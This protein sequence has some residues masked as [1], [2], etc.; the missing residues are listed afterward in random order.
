MKRARVLAAVAVTAG[1]VLATGLGSILAFLDGEVGGGPV[2]RIFLGQISSVRWSLTD[3]SWPASRS[4]HAMAYDASSDCIVLFGGWAGGSTN[5][6]WTFDLNANRWAKMNPAAAPSAR[7]C[8]AMA[9]DA[10]SRRV[11]L[12]GGISGTPNGETWSYDSGTNTWT[13]RAPTTAPPA[14]LGGRMVYD[15][16]FDRIILFGGH[17]GALYG[18]TWAYDYES[19]TWTARSPASS[20][21][22]RAWHIMAYDAESNRTV[23]YGGD[24]GTGQS[25]SDD[26]G[27]TWTYDYANDTWTNMNPAQGPARKAFASAAYDSESDRVVLFGGGVEPGETCAYDLNANAWTVY[28]VTPRPS[29]RA[30]HAMAYD[31]ESDHIVLFS[32]SWPVGIVSSPTIQHNNETWSYDFNANDWTLLSPLPDTTSPTIALTFP[33][34]G[35]VLKS[36]SV[37]VSGTASDNVAVERVE[38]SKDGTNWVLADGTTSWS[39]TLTLQKGS[40]T[41]YARAMDISGNNASTSISVSVSI[42]SNLTALIVVAGAGTILGA[43]VLFLV[44]RRRRK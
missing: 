6:T 39:G 21:S 13:N 8:A 31:S 30:T 14:R 4:Y 20:P 7:D 11:I 24:P 32:G 44:L 1:V 22:P 2:S 36:T 27:D 19:N 43:A 40:N 38:L 35:T 5:E 10:Q 23:L 37:T 17:N 42:P 29:D 18:D 33:A 34:E 25:S 16:Q 26:L 3:D 41:I 12:F 15:A 28:N 9:Y